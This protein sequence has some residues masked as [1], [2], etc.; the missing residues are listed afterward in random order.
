MIKEEFKAR[1]KT[2][3]GDEYDAFIRALEDAP[4]VRGARLNLMKATEIHLPEGYRA[5]PI[6]YVENGYILEGEG[7]IG[8]SPEHHAGMIYMQDPGAMAALAATEI[9]PDHRVA[10]LCAAPGGKS[11]QAAERLGEGGFLLSNEFVPKRAKILVGNLE[12]LGAK[13]AMVTSMDTGEIAK[14]FGPYFDLVIVDAPCSGEGMF[15]KSEEAR[16]EWTPESPA[17]CKE[18]QLEII[19][20]AYNLTRPGGKLLYS[21]CTWSMEENEEVCL[22]LMKSHPDMTLI[23]V[24]E[25]LR[26]ATSDGI[27][28]D[29]EETLRLTRRCYP[30]MTDGEGQFI[31]LFKKAEDDADLPTLIY[32]D[33]A[34]PLS[35]EEKRIVDGF[36]R[37]NLKEMP[38]GRTVKVGENIVHVGHDVPIPPHSVFMAGVLVGEIRKGILYPHHQLFSAYGCHFKRIE[39]LNAGDGRCERYLRG[40]E[41]EATINESGWCAVSYLGATVGGGKISGGRIKNHYPKGLRNS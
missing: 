16:E 31:A 11:S 26:A 40:E 24:R 39:E 30:H 7:Q 1:M 19:E 18:R 33:S 10:D 21:T 23:P 41:I 17:L 13:R 38:C 15:R 8:R 32:K 6:P 28:I 9:E 12:R 20:N 29:G 3:L 14:L 4:P 2:M 22:A 27:V 37:D 25:E 36:F 35:R 5:E 34:K